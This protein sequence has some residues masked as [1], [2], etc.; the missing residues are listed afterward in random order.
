MKN[1]HK[2]ERNV[3]V[4]LS[5]LLDKSKL[6]K[7]GEQLIFGDEG[8]DLFFLITQM[9]KFDKGCSVFDKDG[10]VFDKDEIIKEAIIS[11]TKKEQCSKEFFYS[12]L[13]VILDKRKKTREDVYYV[14]TGIS[15][16]CRVA[17]SNSWFFD[18]CE[19]FL[20]ERFEN[21]FKSRNGDLNDS[22]YTSVTVKVK[23]RTVRGAMFKGLK[24]LNVFRAFC[25]FSLNGVKLF[26]DSHSLPVNELR[27][28]RFHTV[29]KSNGEIVENHLFYEKGFEYNTNPVF[30]EDSES[31][32]INKN[33]DN[34]LHLI[35]NSKY[36]K[37]MEDALERYVDALDECDSDI[38]IMKLWGALEVLLAK[39]DANC[40]KVPA[41]VAAIFTNDIIIK[42]W[43]VSIK[44]YRNSYVHRGGC[45]DSIFHML[46]KF[47]L[48][49]KEVFIF[50]LRR[51]ERD[52]EDVLFFLDKA[53]N[54]YSKIK[55]ESDLLKKI[56]HFLEEGNP[57]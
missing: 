50:F 34:L 37:L 18:G 49:F 39:G 32:V 28:S 48:I 33:I 30:F 51:K 43:M 8:M 17:L 53:S 47:G 24:A 38:A 31:D 19:I 11:C 14:L 12:E 21:K 25:C 23:S 40:E 9:V 42:E 44:D 54:G 20:S 29:H 1:K 41:R 45:G 15:L 22:L 10:A 13:K 3:G 35:S 4:V 55:E 36:S 16:D 57:K 5:M 56:E 27:L 7:S 46:H 52:I 6:S 2:K 26:Y